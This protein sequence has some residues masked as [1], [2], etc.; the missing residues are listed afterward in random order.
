MKWIKR[1]LI[2][3]LLLVVAVVLVLNFFLGDLVKKGAETAGPAALGVPVT[4]E[5]AEFRLLRGQVKLHGLVV[6]NPEG[7]NT[8]SLFQFSQ[9]E[10]KLKPASLLSDTIIIEKVLI[11]AP[12]ITYERGLRT[13]N[14]NKLLDQLESEPKPEPSKEPA[15]PAKA[16]PKAGKKVI[17]E[18]FLINGAKVNV[19]LTALGGSSATL[20]L[21]PIHLTDIGKEKEGGASVKDVIRQVFN[22]ILKSVTQLVG[23]SGELLGKGAKAIGEG[24]KEAG[25]AAADVAGKGVEKAGD[26]VKGVGKAVGGLLKKGSKDEATAE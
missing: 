8:P 2:V 25:G 10:V 3:L 13:S 21:P 6:G 19:S 22:A 26:A 1:I 17:I 12:V 9:V 16:E 4:L 11:E 18:D 24:A 7:F 5:K 14:I 15:P 23:A 20:P